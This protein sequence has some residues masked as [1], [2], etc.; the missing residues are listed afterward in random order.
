V[1][2]KAMHGTFSAELVGGI[3]GHFQEF[4]AADGDAGY[5]FHAALSD[6]LFHFPSAGRVAF[7]C[8]VC[9]LLAIMT[10]IKSTCF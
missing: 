3:K 5:F 1:P 8:I 4:L 10:S 9:R 7:H 2:R 6:K